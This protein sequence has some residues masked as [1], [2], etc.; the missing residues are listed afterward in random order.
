MGASSITACKP[1]V[2]SRLKAS[3]PG[4][5]HCSQERMSHPGAPIPLRMQPSR[6][7][8]RSENQRRFKAIWISSPRPRLPPKS[9]QVP[10][11]GC[12]DVQ[13]RTIPLNLATPWLPSRSSMF[14]T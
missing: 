12:L 1:T 10:R 5:L 14:G 7:I 13:Y 3:E 11:I 2:R 9:G 4:D 8:L 6:S